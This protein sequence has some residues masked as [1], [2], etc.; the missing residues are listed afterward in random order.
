MGNATDHMILGALV[1]DAATM[2]LHWIYD[3]NQIAKIAPDDPAFVAPDPAHYS[4]VP[5]YF[6]HAA[7]TNGQ[8]SQYGEQLKVMRSALAAGDGAFNAQKFITAFQAHFGYGGAYV[9][10]IDHATR[11]SLNAYQAASAGALAKGR[12]VPWDGDPSVTHAMVTKALALTQQFTGDTLRRKFEE[13]VRITHDADA[14][15]AYGLKVLDEVVA[16]PPVTGAVDVQLPA[17]AK[18]PPLV[19]ALSD[20]DD[21]TFAHTVETAICL[22]SNHE[23]SVAYGLACARMMRAA[24]RT[25]DITAIMDAGLNGATEEVAAKLTSALSMKDQDTNTVT[26]HFGLA[27]DLSYGVP[28]AVHTIATAPSFADAVRRNIYAGGDNC[29]RAILIGAIMGAV[30]GVAGPT[31]IPEDWLENHRSAPC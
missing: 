6:A 25:T 19:A 23:A 18:L 5:G 20:E 24:L 4:G 2:G 28:S 15:V 21:T 17:I 31:G 10:Y 8:N 13:A 29:G 26:A 11:E 3:Q 27:C 14:T 7:R 22:T 1:A 9:G 12:A 30:H 16:M